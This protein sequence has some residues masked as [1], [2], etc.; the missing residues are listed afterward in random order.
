MTIFIYLLGLTG[1]WFSYRQNKYLF[2][3]G[4]VTVV[5][6]AVTFVILQTNWNQYR[7]I[8]PAYPLMILLLLS[9]MYYFFSLPKF[10][11]WQFL[12]FVPVIIICFSMLSDTSDAA[13][14]TGKLKNEYSG[15]TPDWLNYAK[16]SAWCAKNLPNDALVA[17]R[18]PSISSIY[19]KGKKFYGIYRVTGGS[20][21]AFY[22]RWQADSLLYSIVPLEGMDNQTY[23]ALMGQC[24]ARIYLDDKYYFAIKNREFVQ[25]LSAQNEKLKIISSPQGLSSVI[26]Q[27]GVQTAIFYPD[28]L[29]AP[30]CQAGV[31]HL[32]TANLRLNPNIKDGQIINTVERVAGFIQEKYPGV[33]LK[34]MQIGEQDDEPADIYQM[35][36][37]VVQSVTGIPSPPFHQ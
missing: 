30:L 11:K 8:V 25:Q 32:L 3:S 17:C 6:L 4:M 9:G 18:K 33:F 24:E 34:L 15:L 27:A 19:A 16:A 13:S 7:L 29:L 5:F 14:E 31:T 26:E 37:A 20:F 28:S 2:F 35:N 12:L 21:D 36:W 22:K 1:L 23:S 10:R